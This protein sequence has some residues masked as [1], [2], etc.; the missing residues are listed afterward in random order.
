LSPLA[1]LSP[2]PVKTAKEALTLPVFVVKKPDKLIS[3]G[4]ETPV[5]LKLKGQPFICA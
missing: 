5:S 1:P 2:S 3:I 4:F